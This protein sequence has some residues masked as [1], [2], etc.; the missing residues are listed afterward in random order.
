MIPSTPAS[1]NDVIFHQKRTTAESLNLVGPLKRISPRR[2]HP[3]LPNGRQR[4][5]FEG[6]G[7][8][9]AKGGNIKVPDATTIT[10]YT[11]MN[12]SLREKA[13]RAIANNEKLPVSLRYKGTDNKYGC[14][15]ADIFG[16]RSYLTGHRRTY[17]GGEMVPNLIL[18][19]PSFLGVS[20]DS[21]ITEYPKSLKILL[22]EH[23]G[24]DCHWA[25][26]TVVLQK[27]TTTDSQA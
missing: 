17:F 14:H 26:C 10:L 9:H 1:T 6:H 27:S 18:Y 2:T 20:D 23:Q 12:C 4:V 13:G 19:P 22:T 11:G 5:V 16:A 24:K 8:I 7:L 25:A 15:E 21:V 3:Y